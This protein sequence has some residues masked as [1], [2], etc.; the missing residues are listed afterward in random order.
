[1]R[2]P[3]F[4][5]EEERGLATLALL[6]A[7]RLVRA[8]ATRRARR[9]GARL[10]VP[11]FC[12]G[13]ATLGGTG[14]TILALD[15]LRRLEARG[16]APHALTRGYRARGGTAAVRRIDL[17]VHDAAA[18][19]DEALLLAA[20]A[21]SWVSADRAAAGRAA[22]AAGADALVMDD[23]LQNFSLAKDCSFLL[24]D[25][26]AGFGNGAV[27]PAGPLREDPRRAASRCRA[28]VL[29]GEDERDVLPR[30]AGVAPIL[31]ARLVPGPTVAA[32]AGRPVVAFAGIGRPA[33]FF[34][35]LRGAGVGLAGA[36]AFPDHHHF[37]PAELAMLDRRAADTGAVLATTP[38]D[39]VRL[40]ASFRARV[41][42]V[43]ATL[44]W[45]DDRLDRIIDAVLEEAA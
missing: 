35:T 33:K 28:I 39:A 15:L 18:V 37:T 14:K 25:G 44:A 20:V 17:A 38:K 34:A 16:R 1:M 32:L 43:D 29:V 10:P 31:R 13:N 7:G 19:G 41:T 42:V 3:R 11:V 45:A 21:P 9:Q 12:C 36:V 6:P 23:G 22:V 4:W 5:N 24:I 27:L 30:L 2:P 40:P 26:P 8:V